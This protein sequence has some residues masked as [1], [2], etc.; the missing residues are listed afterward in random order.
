MDTWLVIWGRNIRLTRLKRGMTRAE[1]AAAVGVTV[2]TVSRWEDGAMGIRDSHK[3]KIAE[4]L[5]EN[6]MMLFPLGGG[7]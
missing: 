2:A 5:G 4:V 6:V 7:A 3:L 1:F